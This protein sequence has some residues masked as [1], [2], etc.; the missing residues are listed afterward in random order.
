MSNAVY[1]ILLLFMCPPSQYQSYYAIRLLQFIAFYPAVTL[2][3]VSMRSHES[4]LIPFGISSS[5][6]KTEAKFSLN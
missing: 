2:L 6:F 3:A 1:F 5:G 4:H